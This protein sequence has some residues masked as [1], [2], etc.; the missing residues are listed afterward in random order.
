MK[1]WDGQCNFKVVKRLKLSEIFYC[2][3]E[4]L[5]AL[6][7]RPHVVQPAGRLS[8]HTIPLRQISISTISVRKSSTYSR[9]IPIQLCLDGVIGGCARRQQHWILNNLCG[10]RHAICIGC[11]PAANSKSTE[12]ILYDRS[13][14]RLFTCPCCVWVYIQSCFIFVSGP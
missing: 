3:F 11:L 5:C 4:I 1:T 14:P 6:Y 10:D 7:T 13:R 9:H 2:I 12:H 8:R